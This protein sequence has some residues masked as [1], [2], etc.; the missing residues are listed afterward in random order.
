MA[1]K[2]K[3]KLEDT[4][5]TIERSWNPVGSFSLFHIRTLFIPN[6]L[7]SVLLIVYCNVSIYV[8]HPREI[9][10]TRMEGILFPFYIP[11]LKPTR[12]DSVYNCWILKKTFVFSSSIKRRV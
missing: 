8:R 9:K 1:L 2:R 11:C 3:M 5:Y 4:I 7:F 12:Q 6:S 10:K